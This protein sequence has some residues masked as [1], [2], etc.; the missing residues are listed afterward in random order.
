MSTPLQNALK[1]QGG[2]SS[3]WT[4]LLGAGMTGAS[5]LPHLRDTVAAE[6][7]RGAGIGMAVSGSPWGALGGLPA[8]IQAYRDRDSVLGN[9][10]PNAAD[11][12]PV[13]A[14]PPLDS[15]PVAT[16][17][18]RFDTT[19]YN[20]PVQAARPPKPWTPA[21]PTIAISDSAPSYPYQETLPEDE[22]PVTPSQAP[23]GWWRQ[24][25]AG[26]RGGVPPRKPRPDDIR[27]WFAGV[28]GP[29]GSAT[30]KK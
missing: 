16:G 7:M 14:V 13:P 1:A 25:L 21:K 15:S 20:A 12:V 2:G 9:E 5:F 19:I 30:L 23:I 3:K 22:I 6:P 17:R 29:G 26:G 11:M 28:Y 24:W 18:D 10:A 4:R 27:A 8:A